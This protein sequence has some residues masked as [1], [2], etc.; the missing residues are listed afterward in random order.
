MDVCRSP[1]GWLALMQTEKNPDLDAIVEAA[2]ANQ[3]LLRS[4]LTDITT[5]DDTY[6][7][8]CFRV[9]DRISQEQPDLLYSE[10][11]RFATFLDS[12]NSYHRNIGANLIANL[13]SADSEGRFEALA[14]RYFALLDDEKIVTA[15]Y[16][17]RSAAKI[18]LA[19]PGLREEIVTRLLAVDETH[20]EPGRRDLLKADVIESLAQLLEA[21]ADKARIVAFVQAQIESSSPKTRQAAKAFLKSH[22]ANQASP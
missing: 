18:A 17:A 14:D 7:Y 3:A 4:I 12:S 9:L 6:R 1:A 15:R 8:N 20:H 19:K 22:D 5:K 21:S 11:S 13:T 10:W 16:V 2:K